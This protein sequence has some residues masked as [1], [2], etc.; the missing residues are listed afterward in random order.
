M[1]IEPAKCQC[2][3]NS[4]SLDLSKMRYR[5]CSCHSELW[6]PIETAPKTGVTILVYGYWPDFPNIPDV[7]FAYWDDDD[8]WWAFDGEEMNATHWMFLPEPPK[9]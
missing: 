5:C 8:Q 2:G 6:Q 1:M 3:S 4:W 7:A 9:L